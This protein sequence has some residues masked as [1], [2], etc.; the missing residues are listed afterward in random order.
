M[1]TL[2]WT[3]MRVVLVATIL[4]AASLLSG[5]EILAHHSGGVAAVVDDG[6][7]FYQALGSVNGSVASQFG[8]PWTLFAA[9]GIAAPLPF[10]P[11]SLGWISNNRTV[12]D[13]GSEFNGLTLWNGSIPLFTGTFN[14][15][16]APF[17]QF[18]FFSNSSES[19]LIA[20]DVLGTVTVYLPVP[21]SDP[22]MVASGL[23]DQP[24]I[25]A[26]LLAP[27]P[28]DSPV[29]AGSAWRA[30][31]EDWTAVNPDGYELF[32]LGW[33]YWGSA[34]PQGLVVKFA[35]CGEVGFTGVQ[36]VVDVLLSSNGSW[37][38]FYNG[39][40]GCGDVTLLGPPPVYGS[41]V[42]NFST[43]VAYGGNG[44]FAIVRSFQVGYS[45][46]PADWDAGG[47]VTWMTTLNLSNSSGPR[48]PSVLPNCTEWVSEWS[49]CSSNDSGWYGVLISASGEWLDSYPSSPDGS[50]W[51]IPNLSLVSDEQL[52]VVVPPSWDS[53]SAV[54]SVSSTVP[55][56]SVTGTTFE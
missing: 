15:G 11:N 38:S 10:A 2:N 45:S 56:I 52:V 18:A 47:L 1:S 33:S 9:W 55:L 23:S 22:C 40:Q 39:S 50:S 34:N 28:T 32:V 6:P 26:R 41:Y 13:C 42:L 36:P 43:F 21:M 31:G 44:S 24:W 19:V 35:R 54:L 5:Y 7:T 29:M 48:L 27:F 12:K 20:T 17:W 3:R 8:G 53:Y 37:N 4:V 16:T 46:T 49:R 51:I 30:I 14:S 25:W